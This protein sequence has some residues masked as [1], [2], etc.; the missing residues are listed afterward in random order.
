[1]LVGAAILG[2]VTLVALFD[3][4]REGDSFCRPGM[5]ALLAGVALFY[6]AVIFALASPRLGANL[7][8]TLSAAAAFGVSQAGLVKLVF[9]HRPR[10]SWKGAGAFSVS[11]F[12]LLS[13][14]L[15]WA[16]NIRAPQA[17]PSHGGAGKMFQQPGGFGRRLR[18]LAMNW[19][20]V[21]YS[22]W[23][24]VLSLFWACKGCCSFIPWAC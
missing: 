14:A 6:L 13:L 22:I 23:S 19:R 10:L 1:M 17:N 12:A 11:L 8:G 9:P 18:K 3:G 7:G 20:L 2:T 24:R 21:R 5:A 15:L 16:L 4:K